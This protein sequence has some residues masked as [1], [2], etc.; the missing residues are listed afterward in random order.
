MRRVCR[1]PG[2][3]EVRPTLEWE[4]RVRERGAVR[5][6]SRVPGLVE[7][8]EPRVRLPVLLE[9]LRPDAESSGS[10]GVG[11]GEG[12]W[13]FVR[14]GNEPPV[15]CVAGMRELLISWSG[16]GNMLRIKERKKLFIVPEIR[17]NTYIYVYVYI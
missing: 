17:T 14:S 7:V 4:P 12:N 16:D 3:V 10:R 15:L 8:W 5:R 11:R 13:M 6:A 2:L 9:A 1:V